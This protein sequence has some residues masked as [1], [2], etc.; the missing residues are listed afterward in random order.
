MISKEN[1]YSHEG[2]QN[3]ISFCTNE[4]F[5]NDIIHTPTNTQIQFRNYKYTN[6]QNISEIFIPKHPLKD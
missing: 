5:S 2:N 4:S 1:L 3:S 6:S